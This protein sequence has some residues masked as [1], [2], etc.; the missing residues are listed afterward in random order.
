MKLVIIRNPFCEAVLLAGLGLM[1]PADG[2]TAQTFSFHVTPTTESCFLPT[3]TEL[4][5]RP[6]LVLSE[7]VVKT[8]NKQKTTKRKL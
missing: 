5:R 2:A 4:S 8:K 3:P 7:S 1:S 6:E